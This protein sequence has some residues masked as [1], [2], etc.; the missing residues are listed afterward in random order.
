MAD[1]LQA[2][3]A[4]GVA[5][6]EGAHAE[7]LQSVVELQRGALRLAYSRYDARQPSVREAAR[8]V[9]G[10]RPHAAGPARSR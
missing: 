10:L 5:G 8:E 6:S 7:L 1:D 2:A 4:A 3:V 9:D